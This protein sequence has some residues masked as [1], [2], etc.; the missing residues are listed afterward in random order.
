MG[1]CICDGEIQ[2]LAAIKSFSYSYHISWLD[3]VTSVLMEKKELLCDVACSTMGCLTDL[4]FTTLGCLKKGSVLGLLV[5]TLEC[6]HALMSMLDFL[7]QK[8][9]GTFSIACFFFLFFFKSF[10][11]ILLLLL[12]VPYNG[13]AKNHFIDSIFKVCQAQFGLKLLAKN[14]QTKKQT[15]NKKKRARMQLRW[16][17]RTRLSPQRLE[18]VSCMWPR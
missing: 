16:L 11:F 17:D 15:N 10:S 6:W 4:H 1:L 5:R 18:F 7:F 12:P 3:W 8:S 9:L 2:L 14:K 13:Q